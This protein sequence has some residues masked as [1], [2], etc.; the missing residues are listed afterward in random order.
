[1]V[2]YEVKYRAVT[3]QECNH[4]PKEH[5]LDVVDR[6]CHNKF[7]GMN[8][9]RAAISPFGGLCRCCQGSM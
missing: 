5:C 1:M 7:V 9:R 2:H 3:P 6:Q 8:L 4:V